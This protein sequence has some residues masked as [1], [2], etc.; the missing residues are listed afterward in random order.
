MFKFTSR[1]LVL[2]SAMSFYSLQSFANQEE[3]NVM[4]KCDSIYSKDR[5]DVKLYQKQRD[6]ELELIW[7]EGTCV[8]EDSSARIQIH[9]PCGPKNQ[10]AFYSGSGEYTI[11]FTKKD[12]TES[13]LTINNHYLVIEFVRD[14]TCKMVS[15]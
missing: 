7:L 2:L 1:N 12:E 8:F 10:C 14:F 6:Q 4:Y 15:I 11:I 5:C 13:T 9:L 3:I